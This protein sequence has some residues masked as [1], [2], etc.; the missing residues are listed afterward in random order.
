M[1]GE[2]REAQRVKAEEMAAHAERSEENNLIEGLGDNPSLLKSMGNSPDLPGQLQDHE[3]L[4]EAITVG[5][6]TDLVLL[7]VW[8]SPEHHTAF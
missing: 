7:K 2:P 1:L 8:S 4:Q 5:Y 6:K 3:G